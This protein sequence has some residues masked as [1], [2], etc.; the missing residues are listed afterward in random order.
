MVNHV[1]VTRYRILTLLAAALLTATGLVAPIAQANPAPARL[2]TPP[3]GWNHWN[4]FRCQI[5][6]GIVRE[7]A[8]AMVSTGLRDAGYQYVNVDDCWQA[9]ARDADGRLASDPVT[10]PSG[11]AALADYVHARGL[12]FGI[13]TAVG[14]KSCEGRPASGGHYAEDAATFAD[15]G[16]DYVKLDW[17]GATGDPHALTS[18]FRAS[19][20]S[21]GRSMA[22]GVSRHGSPWLWPDRPADLWRTSADID[23]EWHSMLRNAEEEAGLSGAAGAGKG[24]NDPDMLQIGNGKMSPVEYR[25]HFSLWAVLAAPLLMGND[26][27]QMD[28]E[29]LSILANREVIA[30]DQDP[31]GVPGERLR[32]NGG[33]EVWTRPLAGGDVAVVLFNRGPHSTEIRTSAHEIGLRPAHGYR[34]RDLWTGQEGTTPGSISADVP[35]HGAALFRVTPNAHGP[36]WQTLSAEADY[37]EP[38]RPTT[39]RVS[40]GASLDAPEGWQ[41]RRLSP[42]RYEV[43][44]PADAPTGPAALKLSAGR[45]QIEHVVV[46]PPAPPRGAGALSNHP[47]LETD[48]GWYLP[49]KINQSFGP[50]D[51]CGDCPGGP[52]TIGAKTFETGLGTY[53][54]AQVSYYLGASCRSVDLAAGI[55]REVLAMNWPGAHNVKGT[56]K[57][58]VYADGKPIFETGLLKAGEPAKHAKLDTRGVRELKLVNHSGGD[59]NFADHAD[60]GGLQ[61]DCR[62]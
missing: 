10:F 1:A 11:M 57:F 44:A 34:L 21:T 22:L 14:E 16:V 6:E 37:L 35:P 12:K 8:D 18:E 4:K 56:A 51:F 7:I 29:T 26:L 42:S 48:N 9:A 27:R 62:T 59:G 40:R 46:V 38:G 15:W 53:A 61:F 32:T 43:T 58:V 41:M 13:Y 20:D 2:A 47:R 50:D 54:S 36:A 5:D 49:M 55:D 45:Q 23:D 31:L 30:V 52:L 3:M 19:L 25:A 17:C 28:P 24:W 39:V 60:W 33:E